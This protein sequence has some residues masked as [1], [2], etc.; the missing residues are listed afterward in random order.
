MA[1][2]EGAPTQSESIAQFPQ[3]A[4]EIDAMAKIDQDMRLKD[5]SQPDAWDENVDARNT[6]RM[7]GIVAEI[8]WPTISKVG[9]VSSHNAWLLVQHA[10][11]QV[12]FQEQCLTLIK[13]ESAGEVSLRDIAMLED[14]VRVNKNQP[15]IYGTQFR[16]ITG[17]HKPLPIEDEANVDKRRKKMGMVTLKEEIDGMYEQYGAPDQG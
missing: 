17:E 15:Q 16:D 12:D 8:G 9:E 4:A 1:M 10:D 5:L 3:I 6:E 13:Q 11:H 14:R 7:K 2:S